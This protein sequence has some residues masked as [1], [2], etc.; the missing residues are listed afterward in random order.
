[1][2]GWFSVQCLEAD[3]VCGKGKGTAGGRGVR[4]RTTIE[5]YMG[6]QKKV[7]VDGKKTEPLVIDRAAQGP[8]TFQWQRDQNCRRKKSRRNSS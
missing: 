1:L 3:V 5:K 4:V 8:P 2:Y 6:H 7:C